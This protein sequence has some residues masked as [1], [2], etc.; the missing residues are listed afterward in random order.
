MLSCRTGQSRHCKAQASTLPRAKRSTYPHGEHARAVGEGALVLEELEV[1]LPD[2]VLQVEGRGE[3][4][5]AVVPGANQDRLVGR[6]GPFVPPQCV[7]FLERLLTHFAFKR[8]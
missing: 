5:L 2:V 4:G 1:H 7:R 3:V 6:V 8:C